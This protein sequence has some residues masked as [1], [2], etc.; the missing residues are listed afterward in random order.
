MSSQI[1]I[2]NITANCKTLKLPYIPEVLEKLC[3][4]AVKNNI[5]PL[6]LIDDLFS[7]QVNKRE[8]N[9]LNRKLKHARFPAIKTIE[10]FD[11]SFQPSIS[12][13]KIS[14]L[15]ELNFLSQKENLIFLGPPGVGKTHLASS[16]GIIACQQNI[17]TFFVNATKLAEDMMASLSDCSVASKLK[18]LFNIDLLIIDELG[19]GQLNKQQANLFFRLISDRYEKKSTII[20]SNK[21]FQ[22]WG[23]LFSDSIIASAILDRLL[24]HSHVIN[25]KGESFRLRQKKIELKN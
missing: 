19:Y 16:L 21:S 2:Q 13:Q 24:H 11:F 12:K 7:H 20:T 14:G 1:L 6:K 10:E 15:A 5:P 25:I 9:T 17:H 18:Q 4:L 22:E 3:N 8:E 23:D